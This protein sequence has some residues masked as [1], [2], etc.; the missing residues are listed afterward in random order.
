MSQFNIKAL[1]EPTSIAVIGAKNST[2]SIGYWVV[3]N[4]LASKFNGPVMPISLKVNNVCGILAYKKPSELPVVPDLA[5]IC[6]PIRFVVKIIKELGEIGCKAVIIFTDEPYQGNGD[7]WDKIRHLAAKYN[8]RVLGPSSLGILNPRIN[9]NVSVAHVAPPQGDVA[10]I[11]QS[12]A[13]AAA[14]VD[15]AE[16]RGVGFS[17]FISIGNRIDINF[18][19]LI[20]YLSRDRF[21]KSIALY[22]DNIIDTRRFM[23]AA[24]AAAFKKPIVVVRAGKSVEAAT[25]ARQY[26]GTELSYD[27]AYSAAFQRSGMLR[28][29]DT[30]ELLSAIKTIATIKR[31][32][33]GNRMLIISNGASLAN[34]AVDELIK[35]GCKLAELS[36][37]TEQKL[38][39]ALPG[40]IVTMNP[41][42][43]LGGVDADAYQKIIEIVLEDATF[44]ALLIIHAPQVTEACHIT[45]Q[46][47]I[48]LLSKNKL[49]G[50][51]ILTSWMGEANGRVARQVLTKAGIPSYGTPEVAVKAFDYIVKFRRH[52]KQ[53]IQT[54][55]TLVDLN[56]GSI[57]EV[58]LMLDKALRKGADE[59]NEKGVNLLLSAYGIFP[60]ATLASDQVNKLR[61]EILDDAAFGPIIC[62]GEAGGKWDIEQDAGVALPPLNM[63]LSRYLVVGSIKLGFIRERS[64][65]VRLN[66]VDLCEIL[67]RLSQMIIDFPM[68]KSIL[69]DP[70]ELGLSSYNINNIVVTLRDKKSKQKLAILPYPKELESIYTMKNGQHVLLRPIRHEDE[71]QHQAFDSSL[72]SDD[73][74][75]RYFGARS[76]FTHFE[77]AMLTQIDYE[78]EMAFIASAK[79][80]SGQPETLGVVRA[81]FDRDMN[82]VE[83]AISVRSDL[84]GQGLGKA[85]MLKIIDF[86]RELGF[87]NMVGFTMPTNSGMINLAKYCGFKVTMDYREGNAD[88][89]LKLN[90]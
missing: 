78:R 76:K 59:V 19:D 83:F 45:A 49:K 54:P 44:D 28:V 79:N 21:T 35:S 47:L 13:F 6:T 4:L 38:L 69:I 77:M 42:N 18:A 16:T 23:S 17:C 48:P 84:K 26:S 52:Q 60:N 1:L 63:A 7:I 8:I 88:L 24:R 73:R 66:M 64:L 33:R 67:T 51:I 74:Y 39:K 50:P 41:I 71:P 75:R 11:S 70:L 37:E 46:K 87:K 62:L 72:T 25:I 43:I 3:K 90:D 30:F 86:C 53:L 27:A 34:M 61:I 82:E 58:K 5:A 40:K 81:I 31:S 68:I 80:P 85:L 9:L 20:D 55:E 15:W 22:V 57:A 56:P 2:E 12:A 65:S 29:N 36:Y 89:R 10:V 32:I 14:M